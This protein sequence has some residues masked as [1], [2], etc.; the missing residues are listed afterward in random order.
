MCWNHPYK[1]PSNGEESGVGEIGEL[2]TN[3]PGDMLVAKSSNEY[4]NRLVMTNKMFTLI[5][6]VVLTGD[7]DT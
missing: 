6:T 2:N 4:R 7:K 3:L 5:H 1:P